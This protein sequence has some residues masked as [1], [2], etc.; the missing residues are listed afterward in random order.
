MI[1]NEIVLTGVKETIRD[2]KQFD[3]DALREFN[4]VIN[5]ELRSAKIE[6]QQ[7]VTQE[8]PLSGWNTKPAR[9]PRTRGGAGWPAWD[10]SII[11]AGI[12]SSRAEGKVRGDYTTSVGALKNR[13]AAGVIYE[14]AGRKNKT[15]GKKGFISNL[16]R[17]DTQFMPSR[18][19]W[20]VVDKNR[21]RISKNIYDALEK[22]KSKL[23]TRLNSRS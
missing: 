6:A 22:A 20:N 4:K 9:N 8:P 23:Q 11:R 16:S 21:N 19:V 1:K 2:L 14:V 15:G 18:L 17:R 12:S 5:S 13:S 10:Q 3:K 7:S